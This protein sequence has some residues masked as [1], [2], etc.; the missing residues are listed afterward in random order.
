MPM[1]FEG[2]LLP[3]LTLGLRVSRSH[4]SAEGTL[5]H[6][7]THPASP[8][9]GSHPVVSNGSA[10]VPA[11]K[12]RLPDTAAKSPACE[13]QSWMPEGWTEGAGRSFHMEILRHFEIS[14]QLQNSKGRMVPSLRAVISWKS[15][16]PW[17]RRWTPHG[18]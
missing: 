12:P 1:L 17:L 4:P 7:W 2:R 11:C 6:Q 8:L 9:W 18:A 10:P 16:W 5:G 13:E 3:L 15:S 14:F